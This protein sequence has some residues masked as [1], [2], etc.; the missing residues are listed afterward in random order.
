MEEDKYNL[1]RW[2]KFILY[3][4]GMLLGSKKPKWSPI[5]SFFL[6]VLK[7][8]VKKIDNR[9]KSRF[10]EGSRY[11]SDKHFKLSIGKYTYG[12]RQ[13]WRGK[14]KLRA[15]GSF[16]SRA[17]NITV[18]EM[19]HPSDFVTTNPILYLKSRGFVE[20]K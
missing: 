11:I 19:N 20:S 5:T 17:S 3:N 9:S 14:G 1:S 8:L 10:F 13:F 2:D 7:A 6:A 15:I 18:V 12:F 4:Y 16:C